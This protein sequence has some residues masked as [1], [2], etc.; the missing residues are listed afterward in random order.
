MA[1]PNTPR[2]TFKISLTA[3]TFFLTLTLVY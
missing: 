2:R 1:P 3:L